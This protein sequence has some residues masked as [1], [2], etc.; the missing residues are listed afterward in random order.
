MA[1]FKN[2][3]PKEAMTKRDGTWQKIPSR[4]LVPGD[5]IQLKGGDNIPADVVLTM[6]NE[7]KVNNASLTGES[8]DLLRIVDS[9]I[10]NVFESPNVAFFGTMCITGVG[11]G[12]VFKTGDATVIGRIANLATSAETTQ[13]PINMEIEHFIKMIAKIAIALGVLFFILGC[14]FKYSVIT[15]LI[16]T[17]GIIVANVPEGLLATVTVCLSLTAKRMADKKVLVKNLEA[18]ETLGSTSCICSDKTGT[19]TQNRMTVSQLFFNLK[20][21]DATNN[22]EIYKRL[23][24]AEM[25]KG[26]DA[27]IK[28]VQQPGYDTDNSGFRTLVE[29]IGLST[30]SFFSYQLDGEV[31]RSMVAKKNNLKADKLPIECPSDNA[32]YA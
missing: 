25:A 18:V 28:N 31:V 12:I 15:N 3:I 8:E 9:K 21:T 1:D 10:R 23:L 6:A 26:K 5:V 4:L 17:I 29:S 7:M 22:W 30:T 20:V 2:F 24:R 19:L 13:T 16:F 14:I 27:N 11:E 32:L